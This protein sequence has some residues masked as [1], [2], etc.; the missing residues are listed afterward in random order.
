MGRKGGRGESGWKMSIWGGERTSRKGER[1][2]RSCQN[3]TRGRSSGYLA[4]LI[5]TRNE[6][7]KQVPFLNN[8]PER[9]RIETLPPQLRIDLSTCISIHRDGKNIFGVVGPPITESRNLNNRFFLSL[10]L[11]TI[12]LIIDHFRV[13]SLASLQNNSLFHP[14]RG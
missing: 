3:Q 7:M 13:T 5:G 14:T 11:L 1:V 9:N 4:Y 12:S 6:S 8:F 2:E 10:S